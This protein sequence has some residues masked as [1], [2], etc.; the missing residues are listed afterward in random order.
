MAALCRG[1]LLPA[2]QYGVQGLE[3]LRPPRLIS[4]TRGGV[5]ESESTRKPSQKAAARVPA[6]ASSRRRCGQTTRDRSQMF[7]VV[8]DG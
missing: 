1:Q 4:L 5:C 6:R 2:C 7:S 3:R 8:L